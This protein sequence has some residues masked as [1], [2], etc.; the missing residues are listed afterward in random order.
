MLNSPRF[1]PHLR[2]EVVPGEGA[3]V[4]SEGKHT[5]LRGR[6]YE[7]VVPW[8]DGRSADEVCDQLQAQVTAAEVYFVLT[9]LEQK[10]FL[11]E[12]ADSLSAGDAAFWSAQQVDPGV[13]AQRRAE[14]AVAVHA[15]GVEPG[16]LGSLLQAA[17]IRV[18]PQGGRLGVVL[19][20][21]YLNGDL[22]DFN[23]KALRDERPWLLV[24]PRGRQIWLGPLFRPG[25]SGCWECLAERLRANNP[26]ASYL[27]WKKG[28]PVGGTVAADMA[29]TPASLHVAWGLAANAVATWVARG[30]DLPDLDGKL[31]TFDVPSWQVQSHT[32]VR[33]PYC[34]ACGPVGG[35]PPRPFR[36]LELESRPKAITRDGGHRAVAPEVTLERYGHHVSPITGAVTVLERVGPAGD[37]DGAMH[38]YLAGHNLASRHHSLVHLR[39]DLR[40]MSSGKGASDAQARAS[41]LCEGL[42]RYSAVYRGDEPR[43]RDRLRRLGETAIPLN[44]CLLF[45]ERQ[46]RERDAWN[47]RES[48]FNFVPVPFDPEAEIEWSSVWSL[49]RR[50]T[51]Y[52][53]T[54][55]CYFNYPQAA[56]RAFCRSCSNGNAAGNNLEE[57][58]LQGFLELVER[59][60]VALW[61][62]N[63]VQRPG[64]DLD[65]VT[66]PYLGRL[67]EY[68]RG[69]GRELWALDLTSD[70]GVPVFAALTRAAEEPEERIV[71]GFGAHFDAEVALLRAVT[72]MNQML[73]GLLH[74]PARESLPEHLSDVETVRWLRTATVANQPYLLPDKASPPRGVSAYPRTWTDDVTDDVRACQGLV[75]RLGL[76]MLVLDQTRPE[77]GLPVAKVIV[78]GLRHFW[79]RFAPGRLYDVPVRLGWLPRPTPEDELNPIP[80]FL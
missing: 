26:V 35:K 77:I 13:A 15:F 72:E 34:P 52:L 31:R 48:R 32:L 12:E 69:R 23:A 2:V 67:R 17:G 47:A 29:C 63:R 11:C 33:L 54:A 65:S 37:G 51:R 3:F 42:E 14:M 59:D 36:P 7:C 53:P 38:V 41:G 79:A 40:N 73:S 58:I 22:K 80:M 50:E 78:P 71:L 74:E 30:G 9:Q 57:A 16:P 64:V 70:L 5:L 43:R 49:T 55:F 68:L 46:Y 27:E 66:D 39:G 21:G 60:A 24:R 56:D 8:V 25:V 28:R 75:E 61:W 20:D 45:S 44:D 19:A 18:E 62:Y 76:E 10:G 6:L 1:K 4:L